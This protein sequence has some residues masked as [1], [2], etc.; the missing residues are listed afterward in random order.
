MCGEVYRV[1]SGG[2]WRVSVTRV[3]GRGTTYVDRD[4][5]CTHTHTTAPLTKSKTGTKNGYIKIFDGTA[6]NALI[7][8]SIE[9][10][11]YSR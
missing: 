8:V 5:S 6:L 11:G 10:M 3:S 4:T 9:P 7:H 1:L 2:V